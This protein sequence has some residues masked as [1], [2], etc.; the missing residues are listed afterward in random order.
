M[1][2]LPSFRAVM[3]ALSLAA[4][5]LTWAA[6]AAA[7]DDPVSAVSAVLDAIEAKEFDRIADLAC[8]DVRDTVAE[9]FDFGA[10]LGEIPGVDADAILAG[11]RVEV[12]DRSV[13]LLEQ[14]ATS[15]QVSVSAT[16]A[17][18]IDEA[19]ARS[20]VLA[21]VEAFGME[22]TE[23]DIEG[24]VAEMMAE[25]DMGQEL[26]GTVEVVLEDGN[27][28]LCDDLDLDADDPFGDDIDEPTGPA[29][30]N[31]CGLLSLDEVNALSDV[32]FASTDA[33]AEGSCQYFPDF[34]AGEFHMLILNEDASGSDLAMVRTAFPDAEEVTVAGRDGFVDDTTATLFVETERGYLTVTAVV[35][36]ALGPDEVSAY[37]QAIA[38]I[39]V[40]RLGS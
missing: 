12:Q 1:S 2:R 32:Q 33:S 31:L 34:S 23:E 37:L 5:P 29:E 18:S 22:A 20:I 16:I 40:P 14:D 6:P 15:A 27:W 19:S 25:M 24:F 7:Q 9:Q 11:M 28:R 3:L 17:V 35:G 36:D 13:V 10:Q 26:D 30:G 39:V 8:E 38:E 21:I 4:L